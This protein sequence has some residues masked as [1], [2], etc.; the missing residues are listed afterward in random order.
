MGWNDRIADLAVEAQI[1]AIQA[2]AIEACDRGHEDIMITNGDPDANSHAY[3]L[4]TIR[5][6][7]GDMGCDRQEFMDAIKDE[8]DQSADECPRCQKN[9]ED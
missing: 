5:W 1:V 4:G 3:A 9:R 7:R 6:Q 2:K 8:I